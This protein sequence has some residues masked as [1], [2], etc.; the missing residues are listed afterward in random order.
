MAITQLD[1][2]NAD[3][4]ITS[5]ITVLTDTPNASLPKQCQGLIMLGDGA[6]NLDGTGGNF[7]FTVSIDGQIVQ[8]SPQVVNFDTSGRAAVW[9]GVFPVPANV[10]VLLRVKSPNAADTDVDVTAF[11]YDVGLTAA[12]INTEVADVL[13]VDTVTLPGQIAP[14]LA[15]TMQQILGHLFKSYRNRKTGTATEWSLMADDETT[16]DQKATVSDDGI[17]TVKQEIVAGP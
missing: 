8:P 6:K 11:L 7:E 3:R 2:E 10:E 15:P 5:I 14:P 9:T 12:N 16:V 4:N 13:K 1:T 17:T